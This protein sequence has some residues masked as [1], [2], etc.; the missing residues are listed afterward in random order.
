MDTEVLVNEGMG[1]FLNPP[2]HPEH[3]WSVRTRNDGSCYSLS[4]AA[5]SDGMPVSNAAK[6]AAQTKLNE[7]QPLPL[8]APETKKWI[9]QILG[10][11]NGCYQGNPELGEESWHTNRIVIDREKTLDPVVNQN[12]HCGVHFI[13][14]WYPGYVATEEDFR[15]AKWGE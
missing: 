6:T 15:L 5:N 14:K 2:G 13:R 1:G 9:C 11:F 8:N 12:I 10:Y 3:N 7:W 4:Y